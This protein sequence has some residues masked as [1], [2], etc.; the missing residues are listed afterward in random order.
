MKNVLI[1]NANPKRKSLCLSLADCYEIEARETANI[2]RFNL[3]DMAFNPSLDQGYDEIQ[4]LEPCLVEFQESLL[5]AEH[6]VIVTST[7]WGGLPAKMK[8]L[9]DRVFI[10]G[11][12]FKFEA[13]NPYPIPLMEGKTAR[14]ILTMDM[15]AEYAQEQ[16]RPVLEQLSKYTLEYCG[17]SPVTTSLFGSVIMSDLDQKTQWLEEASRLGKSLT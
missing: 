14:I 10:P 7:W 11:V 12:T 1:L 15:P 5:W 8:G 17:V 13:D 2:R 3:S 6:I 16:A 4:A 9:I